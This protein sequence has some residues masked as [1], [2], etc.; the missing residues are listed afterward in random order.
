[1][2]EERVLLGVKQFTHPTPKGYKV[3]ATDERGT[4]IWCEGDGIGVN[5]F[6]VEKNR[7]VP[8][9]TNQ[10][11]TPVP[12]D[13]VTCIVIA[14]APERGF[15][16]CLSGRVTSFN[17]GAA[18][19]SWAA[20]ASKVMALRI[21]ADKPGKPVLWSCSTDGYLKIWEGNKAV[22][23]VA[24]HRGE[25]YDVAHVPFSS[26]A[27]VVWS[28]G[29]D[30]TIRVW[31]KYGAAA[32][33][34][35]SSRRPSLLKCSEAVTMLHVDT[36]QDVVWSCDKANIRAWSA[37]TRNCVWCSVKGG[38]NLT[39]TTS[40][41]AA[42]V[43]NNAYV[44]V[45]SRWITNKEHEIPPLTVFPTQ[46]KCLRMVGV[47][48]ERLLI[49]TGR[50]LSVYTVENTLVD[51]ACEIVFDKQLNE[52]IGAVFR[53]D[54]QLI[55]ERVEPFSA[56]ERCGAPK[57]LGWML[58]H[59]NRIPVSTVSD[60]RAAVRK[61][62]I[63]SFKFKQLRG[64]LKPDKRPT[65]SHNT[66]EC[67][68]STPVE[69]PTRKNSNRHISSSPNHTPEMH[70]LFKGKDIFSPPPAMREQHKKLLGAVREVTGGPGGPED[71]LPAL[72]LAHVGSMNDNF[73]YKL[74]EATENAQVVGMQL[75]ESQKEIELLNKEIKELKDQNK[76]IKE[77]ITSTIQTAFAGFTPPSSPSPSSLGGTLSQ[78]SLLPCLEIMNDTLVLLNE[79]PKPL[80]NP[81]VDD[82]YKYLKE[83]HARVACHTNS[84]G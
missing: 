14:D 11:R 78:P 55:L 12:Q 34:E 5:S 58:T 18:D 51:P 49:T 60:V 75:E 66:P 50:G 81:T 35:G 84:A 63:F 45:W 44:A 29:F 30:K 54:T 40:H 53:G 39:L 74:Q 70:P 76:I 26:N 62:V 72:L 19:S 22:A 33:G 15:V 8:F 61:Q 79:A 82:L 57:F 47:S 64:G 25:V 20:H 69:P 42:V 13:I 46:D 28:C 43:D 41:V 4:K 48:N 67:P 32:D 2:G 52:I 6:N 9:G 38:T 37:D 1:M 77:T 21:I 68:P 73:S 24:G 80:V 23:K 27:G 36:D 17:T 59:V 65:P 56:A 10:M 3:V 83:L 16:G 7:I 31:E 71:D